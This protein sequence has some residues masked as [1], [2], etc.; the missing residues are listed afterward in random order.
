[1]QVKLQNLSQNKDKKMKNINVKIEIDEEGFEAIAEKVTES[2]DINST[3]DDRIGDYDYDGILSNWFDY[4]AD[5]D[6]KVKDVIDGMDLTSCIDADELNIENN[7]IALLDNYN[8]NTSCATGA[9]FTSAIDTAIG[10]LLQKD[11]QFVKGIAKALE[12]HEQIALIKEVKA[13][14][15]E[16]VKTELYEQFR[17]EL[18]K[19]AADLKLEEAKFESVLKSYYPN[20]NFSNENNQ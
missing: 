20:T 4:Y 7:I 6:D 18:N 2:M 11:E 3:I 19:Y 12:R 10:Y 13:S 15:I 1:M 5:I 16:E 8:P 14:L 9:V 17:M